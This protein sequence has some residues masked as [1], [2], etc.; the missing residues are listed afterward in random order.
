M[1]SIT[2]LKEREGSHGSH[3]MSE[4]VLGRDAAAATAA[5]SPTAV[6]AHHPRQPFTYLVFAGHRE[7]P[8]LATSGF[9]LRDNQQ[10]LSGPSSCAS[11]RLWTTVA[12]ITVRRY[13]AGPISDHGTVRR[14]C[15]KTFRTT[16]AAGATSRCLGVSDASSPTA[17]RRH[18]S[19]AAG[20]P[21][22][23]F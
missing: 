1:K 4:A 7:R 3:Q 17:S 9:L 8:A 16:G 21:R 12:R 5:V 14:A 11:D 6:L 19:R 18:V 23:F 20:C 10:F 22:R 2:E 15:A 13:P